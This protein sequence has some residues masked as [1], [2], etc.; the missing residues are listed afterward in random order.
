MIFSIQSIDGNTAGYALNIVGYFGNKATMRLIASNCIVPST[1]LVDM[2]ENPDG[3][4]FNWD[5]TFP[6]FNDGGSSVRRNY[7]CVAI[8]QES[9]AITDVLNCD[10]TKV[11][12]AYQNRDPR[13]CINVITPYSHYLGTDAGS[14]PMDKQFILEDASKGGSP[15][16]A[17]A[18]IRNSEG[19]NS[20]FWRKWIPTGNLDGYW[21]E[22]NR[23]P[24][25]FP[26]IRLGDV[27]LMLSEAYNETNQLSKAIVELNKIRARVNMPGL[28]SGPSWLSVTSKDEM[29]Q[30][31]RDERAYELV[32]EGQR[33]WDLRRWGILKSTVKNATDIFGDLMY[34]RTYQARHE[35]WPIPLVE[36]ERNPNLKQNDGWE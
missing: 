34:Q 13:L 30:R 6:G 33:Y 24:Y 28:N 31:I 22:Y 11:L 19:W 29:T 21:G 25:E 9:T 10:T 32:G 18:F 16:E 5:D 36:L 3:S 17:A 35:I 26:L 14:N 27:I 15:M 1:T 12:A 20:Y 8:N 2:Y 23:T 7:L 4:K